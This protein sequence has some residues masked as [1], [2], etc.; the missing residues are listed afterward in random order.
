MGFN[1]WRVNLSNQGSWGSLAPQL[2]Y[3]GKSMTDW[4]KKLFNHAYVKTEGAGLSKH[5]TSQECTVAIQILDLQPTNR[6]LD[7]ACGHGRHSIELARRGF[8]NVTGLD[9]NQ[10]ALEQAKSDAVGTS[11]RFIHGD[12]HNLSFEQE[13]DVVLSFFNSVFYWDDATHLQ[14][15][16]GI[17]KTLRPNGRLMLD[18]YNP[19]YAVHRKLLEQHPVFGKAIRIKRW[20]GQVARELQQII[21]NP[22]KK[23]DWHETKTIFYPVTGRVCGSKKIVANGIT[24]YFPLEIRLYSFTEIEKLL[25]QSGFKIEKVVSSNGAVFETAS[26]RFMIIAKAI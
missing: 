13:F 7:L 5:L 2:L 15:F 8:Q 26:P 14:I 21:K 3:L 12:M 1:R 9:F 10:A 18:S 19:F 20:F 4:T 11:A 16:R 6:I 23:R 24:E 22:F 17:H 25:I